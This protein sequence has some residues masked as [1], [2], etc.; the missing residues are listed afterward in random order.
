MASVVRSSVDED[1]EVACT[2][3]DRVAAKSAVIV[4]KC[5]IVQYLV[6]YKR[7]GMQYNRSKTNALGSGAAYVQ[8]LSHRARYVSFRLDL[9]RPVFGDYLNTNRCLSAQIAVQVTV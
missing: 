3:A 4:S 8:L 1:T 7:K 6:L 2:L 5:F 9:S